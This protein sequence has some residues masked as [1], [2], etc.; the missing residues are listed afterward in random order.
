MC[1]YHVDPKNTNGIFLQEST[2]RKLFWDASAAGR[3]RFRAFSHEPKKKD[4]QS[5]PNWLWKARVGMWPSLVGHCVRDAGV[6]RS[7]RA[8]PTIFYSQS[9]PPDTG[10][11]RAH[12]LKIAPD[13][14]HGRGRHEDGQ[15][16]S[17]EYEADRGPQNTHQQRFQQGGQRVNR[18][19][20]LIIIKIGDFG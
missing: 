3:P 10:F 20:H 6:A 2:P 9:F 12:R 14:S 7:N 15:I 11:P 13:L 19:I 16:H 18:R 17:D 4:G 8:I 1:S 5:T